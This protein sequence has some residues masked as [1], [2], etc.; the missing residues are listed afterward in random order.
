MLAVVGARLTARTKMGRMPRDPHRM[1]R[2]RP[3]RHWEPPE[4]ARVF[5]LAW[6]AF[7]EGNGVSLHER[8][9]AAIELSRIALGTVQEADPPTP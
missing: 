2:G 4:V 8:V 6:E 5:R 3:M 1:P 9:A 7:D